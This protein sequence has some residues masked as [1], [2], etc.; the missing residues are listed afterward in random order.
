MKLRAD[1]LKRV[2]NSPK[3]EEISQMRFP[4]NFSEKGKE[5]FGIH[6]EQEEGQ[7]GN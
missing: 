3:E 1:C 7:K 4:Q 2:L 5:V 6:F